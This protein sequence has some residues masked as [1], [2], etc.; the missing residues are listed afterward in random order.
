MLKV[1]GMVRMPVKTHSQ[2]LV[3]GKENWGETERDIKK[4]RGLAACVCNCPIDMPN[5]KDHLIRVGP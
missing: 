2:L 4:N 5:R 3:G 1:L